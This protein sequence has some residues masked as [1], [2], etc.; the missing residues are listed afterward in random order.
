MAKE[1]GK[2]K[3][4]EER[5]KSGGKPRQGRKVGRRERPKEGRKRKG[6]RRREVYE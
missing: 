5:K 3:E 6:A 1:G 2:E 4:W